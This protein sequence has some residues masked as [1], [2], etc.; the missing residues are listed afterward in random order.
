MSW[1]RAADMT[2]EIIARQLRRQGLPCTDPQDAMLDEAA[3]TAHASVWTLHC[4]EGVYGVT[5]IPH[6][7]ARISRMPGG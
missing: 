4:S 6:L 5:L 2:P 7:G 1:A 3:S